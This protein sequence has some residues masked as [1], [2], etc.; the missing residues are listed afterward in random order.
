MIII[1][2]S[3]SPIA[4]SSYIKLPYE[5]D[6]PRKGLI[7]IKNTDDNEYFEWC[8]AR[9]LHP[10]DHN[11]AR[12]TKADKDFSKR[13]DFKDIKFPLKVRDISLASVFLV[14]KIRRNI[15]STYLKNVVKKKI[16]YY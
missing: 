15:Q 10:T 2:Q 11:P 4:G 6:H 16:I 1:F 8:L 13:L 14:M 7:D 12:N 3:T 5:L 9:C